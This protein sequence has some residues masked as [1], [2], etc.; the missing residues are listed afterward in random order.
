MYTCNIISEEAFIQLRDTMRVMCSSAYEHYC[1]VAFLRP[2][3][4]TDFDD[5]YVNQIVLN[6]HSVFGIKYYVPIFT[7]SVAN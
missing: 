7:E 6:L 1:I 4:G 3:A 2:N 5:S